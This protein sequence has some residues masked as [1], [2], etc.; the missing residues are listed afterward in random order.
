MGV[1]RTAS[2]AAALALALAGGV[3]AQAAAAPWRAPPAVQEAARL[4]AE[5]LRA[6]DLPVR[7]FAVDFAPARVRPD[8]T[9]LDALSLPGLRV[10]VFGPLRRQVAATARALADPSRPRELDVD[11]ESAQLLIH[12]ALHQVTGVARYGR[13]SPAGRALE[14]GVVEAVARDLV[15][16]W[17]RE[18]A[19]IRLAPASGAY[20]AQ[21]RWVRDASAAAA[22]APWTDPAAAAWRL[23]LLRASPPARRA[24]TAWRAPPPLRIG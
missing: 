16:A 24:M 1:H 2:L 10:V 4:T 8:G 20:D 12:E 19:G 5:W 11:G 6:R 3:P 18:V 14:E 22:R 17:G 15:P 23:E 9:F 7:A 13:L 21:V